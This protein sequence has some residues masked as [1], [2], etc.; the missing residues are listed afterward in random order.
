MT[1]LN[2]I[3]EQARSVLEAQLAPAV[4]DAQALAIAQACAAPLADALEAVTALLE[5]DLTYGLAPASAEEAAPRRR[6][7]RRKKIDMQADAPGSS[8]ETVAAAP[9]V[10]RARKQ[11]AASQ[12]QPTLV[13]VSSDLQQPSGVDVADQILAAPIAEEQIELILPPAAKSSSDPLEL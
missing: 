8:A 9:K 12:E 6:G 11:R 13:A 1:L 4:A 5:V 10:R 3:H 7:G 2:I